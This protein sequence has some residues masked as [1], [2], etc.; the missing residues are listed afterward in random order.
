MIDRYKLLIT[1]RNTSYFLKNLLR[2]NVQ[3]YKIENT[4]DGIKI[5]VDKKDYKDIINMKT[6]YKIKVVNRYGIGKF[7]YLLT[8]YLIF[9]ISLFI[10]FILLTVLSN[11]IFSIQVIHTDE[12]IR[13]IVLRDLEEKGIKKYHFKVSFEEKEKIKEYILNKETNDIEWLEIEEKGTKYVVRVE[14]RKKNK[15]EEVCTPRNIIAKKDAMI[16]SINSDSGEIVK[17]KLDYVKKGDVLISG[18]IHNKETIVSKKCAEG[19]VF[20]EVWYKVTL[21]LP[22]KYHEEN[23]TGK[24]KSQLEV[25]LFNKSYTLFSNF[26]TYK[27]KVTPI[28]NSQLLPFSINLT[29]YLETEVIEEIYEINTIDKKALKTAS[30]KLK[31]KLKEDDEITYKKV[32][33]KY[34]KNSKII[35]EVFFKVKEDITDTESIENINIEEENQKSSKE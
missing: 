7:K 34:E 9:I 28:L 6:I 14:Q 19:Q 12:D 10:S 5:I 30:D 21:E 31:T 26:K 18:L 2:K 20:G 8:K 1:G 35:V 4:K 24:K 23:V 17:K 3:I 15:K 33:K 25:N 29:K 11:M 22:K 16:L 13:N 32:L 27:K